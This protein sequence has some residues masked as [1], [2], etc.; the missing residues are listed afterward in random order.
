MWKFKM[1]NESFQCESCNRKIEK[2][3][4]WSA[5]NHCPFCLYSKHLDE[6]SPW[7]RLSKCLWLME[8]IW[9]EYKKKKWNMIIHK[10]S[11]CDKQILNKLAPDDDFLGFVSKINKKTLY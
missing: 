7:D 9:I 11:K 2:H 5:R 4:E 10:C 3:P 1:I 8:P 6:K